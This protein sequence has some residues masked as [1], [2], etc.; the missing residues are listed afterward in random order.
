MHSADATANAHIAAIQAVLSPDLRTAKWAAKASDD[1][2]VNPM[3]GH[4]YVAAEVLFHLLGGKDAGWKAMT[5]NHQTFPQGLPEEGDTHWFL[6]HADGRIADPT[7]AQFA[8]HEVP[9]AEGKGCGFLT[10]EPSRRARVVMERMEQN[11]RGEAV[12]L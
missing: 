11:A 5:L 1:Q 3:K 6:Q 9:Y 7:A 4:C 2:A 8:P 12:A 10:R